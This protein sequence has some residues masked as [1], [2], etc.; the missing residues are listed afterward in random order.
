MILLSALW[1]M[2]KLR[3]I[4]F[5]PYYQIKNE[6]ERRLRHIIAHAYENVPYYR[7]KLKSLG[8]KPANFKK[9]ED[10]H[11]LP[12][13]SRD[14]IQ[15]K[16]D[17]FVSRNK[18]KDSFWIKTSG[19]TGQPVNI[20]YS[21]DFLAASIGIGQRFRDAYSSTIQLN[22]ISKKARFSYPGSG[23]DTLDKYYMQ[24]FWSLKYTYY[25]N[26]RLFS[27]FDPPNKNYILLNEF[28]P[29][30][31]AGIGSYIELLFRYMVQNGLEMQNLGVVTYASDH[32]GD[33]VRSTIEELYC[34]VFAHYNAIETGT[35]GFECEAHRGY[36]LS[37]DTCAVKLID[38]DGSPT[39]SKEQGEIVVSNLVN[40]GT[41][42]LNYRLGDVGVMGG[43][44]MDCECG[45]NLPLLISLI[46][47]LDDIIILQD[48][49]LLHPRIFWTIFKRWLNQIIR[50]KL[51]QEDYE[52]YRV[53]CM[54]SDKFGDD[55][56][57]VEKGLIGDF[58]KILGE[59]DIKI[60]FMNKIPS[61]N[62]GKFRSIESRIARHAL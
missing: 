54:L 27:V 8:L 40:K 62:S 61:S 35:I 41:V 2:R 12:L 1:N 9:I 59:S 36:H 15:K 34:P 24:A 21:K 37:I 60:K 4:P 20:L 31:V 18:S 53:F 58:K 10:L 47:R 44:N 48:G 28:N 32:L 6:Q 49:T 52:K 33:D 25:K 42:L 3:K 22:R 11:K 57:N 55:I 45:R 26:F 29:Q 17:D 13:I 7:R 14:D 16:P 38:K 50:Y 56:N 43:D 39:T 23:S 5:L 30:I 51:I 19:V 46:G